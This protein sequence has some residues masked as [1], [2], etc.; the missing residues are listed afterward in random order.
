MSFLDLYSFRYSLSY[1]ASRLNLIFLALSPP[2]DPASPIC[3][4]PLDPLPGLSSS[5]YP[6]VSLCTLSIISSF[7]CM[8]ICRPMPWTRRG[9]LC[10]GG[11][12]VARFLATA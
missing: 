1:I 8:V 10:L 7:S 6:S 11:A 4:L 12:C 9:P 5:R 2:P 3:D